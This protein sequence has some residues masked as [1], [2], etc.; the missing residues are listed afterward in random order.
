M[1]DFTIVYLIQV[2][3]YDR[4]TFS[5][6]CAMLGAADV[7]WYYRAVLL[8]AFRDWWG[9]F[10]VNKRSSFFWITTLIGFLVSWYWQGSKTAMG[11]MMVSLSAL[12]AIGIMSIILF[13][14][15]LI[16]APVRLAQGQFIDLQERSRERDDAIAQLHALNEARIS[17]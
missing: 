12:A 15:K 1:R 2:L 4:A 3:G 9:F 16:C 6:G 14:W 17:D 5:K 10:G 7:K 8:R 13:A 11:E